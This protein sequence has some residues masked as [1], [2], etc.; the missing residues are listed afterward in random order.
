MQAQTNDIQIEDVPTK[1]DN[2]SKQSIIL[3]A[4]NTIPIYYHEPI[5]YIHTRYPT[6]FHMDNYAWFELI[7]N[8]S[9]NPYETDYN[10]SFTNCRPKIYSG[11]IIFHNSEMIYSSV[12]DSLLVSEVISKRNDDTLTPEALSKLWMIPIDIAR[13]TIKATTFSSIRTNEGRIFRRFRTYSY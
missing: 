6:D 5:P 3:D 2:R 10:I 12:I 13:N 4:D 9:W 1:F 8:S 7:A 11:N